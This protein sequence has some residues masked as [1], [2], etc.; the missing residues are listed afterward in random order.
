MSRKKLPVVTDS[1]MSLF[2]WDRS[3]VDGVEIERPKIRSDCENGIRPC[4]FVSC[5]FHLYLQIATGGNLKVSHKG[6]EPWER[7][8]SCALDLAD[9]GPHTLD[10]IAGWIGATRERVRQI[11]T[12]AM[13]KLGE[14][15]PDLESYLEYVKDRW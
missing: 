12:Y 7:E 11:E 13:S 4:P 5:R 14:R 9:D 8:H 3:Y 6:K 15:H 1:Q 2:D 10:A